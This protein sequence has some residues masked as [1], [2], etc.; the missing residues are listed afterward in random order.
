M[1]KKRIMIIGSNGH[2]GQRLLEYYKDNDNVELLCSSIEEYSCYEGIEYRQLN[3]TSKNDV[4]DAIKSFYPDVIINAAAFTNVDACETE[5]DTAWKVN[6]DGVENLAKHAIISDAHLIHISTDYI[7]DGS[8][9]PYDENSLPNPVSYYGRTKLASEN[10]LKKYNIKSTV[11]RINVLYGPSR[12]GKIDFV[13]WVVYSLRGEKTIKIVTDQVNNPTFTEDLVTG[14]NSV[15][16]LGKS[17]IYNMGGADLLSRFEFAKKIAEYFE[18]DDSLI[19][20]IVTS[21]L[22]QAAHRPLNSGLINL[23]AE[24]EL[25]YK[26]GKI[27][28]TFRVMKRILDTEN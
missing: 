1:L 9:G 12:Y 27:D 2:L 25:N 7:F 21:D 26:P 17:G 5:K 14:I 24:T 22:H 16:E 15:I 13:R 4:R 20:K 10:L 28:Q 23:K 18:L 8:G 6:V 3:I 19:E 11:I